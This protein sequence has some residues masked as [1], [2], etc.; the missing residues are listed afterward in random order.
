[1]FS[2]QNKPLEVEEPVAE[3][4][5]SSADI[6]IIGDRAAGKTTYLA[7]LARWSNASPL[8]PVQE[9]T[10]VNEEGEELISKAQN[11]LELGS[12]LEPSVLEAGAST[13]KDY[14]LSITF[15]SSFSLKNPRTNLASSETKLNLSCKEYAGEFFSHLLHQPN[16]DQFQSYLEDCLRATGILFLVDGCSRQDDEHAK[17]LEQFLKVWRQAHSQAENRRI[18]L[19]LTKCEQP[20]LWDKRHQPKRLTSARFPQVYAKLQAWHHSKAGSVEYFT[21]AAFG[22][23]ATDRRFPEPNSKQLTRSQGG[24]MSVLK[25]PKHWRPFGLVAPIY[26]LSTGKRHKQLDED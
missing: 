1:M 23:V 6:R 24:L 12:E 21:T 8:S 10:A 3:M 17:S 14:S 9:I 20:D 25:N 2:H 26:W 18:A 22:M 15:K 5:Q 7:S 16:S 4:A 11:I 13:I 19:V